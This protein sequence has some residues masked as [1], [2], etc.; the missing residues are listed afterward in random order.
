MPELKTD[1]VVIGAG[2]VGLA[3]S[4]RFALAGLE[5]VVVEQEQTF[6]TGT[7]SRNS[8]VIHAGLYYPTGS[9]KANMCLKGREQLYEYC[10]ERRIPHKQLGKLIVATDA[11]EETKLEAIRQQAA[12]NGCD[13]VALLGE[14]EI[15]RE[16][17]ALKAVAM[18]FSPRTGIID[19]HQLMLSLLADL[20]KAGGIVV[21]KTRVE[22]VAA[23]TQGASVLLGENVEVNAAC[24]VNAAGLGAAEFLPDSDLGYGTRLA[25]GDYFSYSGRIPFNRLV[26][27][28]P[29]PGGLGVHLT[30]DLGGAGRFGPDVTWVDEVDYSIDSAKRQLF[31]ERIRKYWPDCDI[32]KLSPSYSGIRSKATRHGE[33][34]D[35]FLFVTEGAESRSKI[36]HL[37]GIESPGLTSFLSIADHIFNEVY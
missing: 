34:L 7:S 5:V 15:D 26:Y 33:V 36:I 21:W 28:V 8:E 10:N 23:S 2:V 16:R 17:G 35:D 3:V 31:F 14:K 27:P 24:V 20:E 6:G 32:E 18:L 11:E 13:E 25:K 22:S 4:R 30:L 37:L 19:S 12:D 1:I 9:L 29:Q